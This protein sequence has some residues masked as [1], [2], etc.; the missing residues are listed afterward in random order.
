MKKNLLISILAFTLSL[1]IL[2]LLC[3]YIYKP[4]VDN[5][6]TT[7]YLDYKEWKPDFSVSC[8]KAPQ[9]YTLLKAVSFAHYKDPDAP[10]KLIARYYEIKNVP[11][12]EVLIAETYNEYY[13]FAFPNYK[14]LYNSETVS[15]PLAYFSPHKATLTIT[16]SYGKGKLLD[17][18][19]ETIKET[20][21]ETIFTNDPIEPSNQTT[22]EIPINDMSYRISLRIALERSEAVV[23]DL[24][25]GFDEET[26]EWYWFLPKSYK[27]YYRIPVDDSIKQ[28]I[29]NTFNQ[30]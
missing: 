10:S 6:N 12:S 21:W 29:L 16:N 30:A 20:L 9:H 19:A 17:I 7:A 4:Y 22:F 28:N 25:V 26:A 11:T 15:D 5:K 2:T 14:V 24:Y 13:I 18:S 1:T 27:T 8:L 3:V 23:T